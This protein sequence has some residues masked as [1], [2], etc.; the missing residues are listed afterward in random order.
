MSL[1]MTLNQ[2]AARS[3]C[4]FAPRNRD[5]PIEPTP[6]GFW[7]VHLAHKEIAAGQM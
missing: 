6:R 2:R 4:L 7:Y 3:V 5:L 1:A